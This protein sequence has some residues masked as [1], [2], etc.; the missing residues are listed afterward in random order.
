MIVIQTTLDRRAMTALAKATRKTLRRG[1]NGPVRLL[2]WLVVI[3]ES[4]LTATYI[5]GGASGWHINLLLGLIM[6]TCILA[7]DL[8]NGLT[9]LRQT[10]AD[11][12]EVNAAFQDDGYTLRTQA[13]EEWWP[14][15]QIQA[16]VETKDYLILILDRRHGQVYDKKGSAWGTLEELRTL[17]QKRTGLKIQTVR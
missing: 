3:L 4:F 13:G 15:R 12:R 9:F 6:L 11:R 8:V 10:P 17:L 2:A 7:E 14:Y 5:Q 16:A 1:R